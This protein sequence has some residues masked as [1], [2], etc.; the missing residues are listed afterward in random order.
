MTREVRVEAG[1]GASVM[2]VSFRNLVGVL[3]SRT[4]DQTSKSYYNTHTLRII[5]QIVAYSNPKPEYKSIN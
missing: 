3:I 1:E 4:N 5:A 2:V